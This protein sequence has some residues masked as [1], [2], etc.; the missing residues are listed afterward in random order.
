MP[1]KPTPIVISDSVYHILSKFSKSRTLPARQVERAKI[2]LLCA[3]GLITY[4]YPKRSVSDKIPVSKWHI[5]FL[6]SLPLLREVEEKI[7]R[8]LRR[9][10]LYF[11]RT[12]PP[13]TAPSLYR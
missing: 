10:L 6:N 5:R 8:N 7:L 3:E 4:K 11:L 9:K 13:Q 1:L 12:M 2:F